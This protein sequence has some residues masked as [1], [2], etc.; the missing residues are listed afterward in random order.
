MNMSA[1]YNSLYKCTFH[2]VKI[3]NDLLE[4]PCKMRTAVE[5]DISDGWLIKVAFVDNFI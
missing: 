5:S 3:S 1:Y 2:T 4:Y